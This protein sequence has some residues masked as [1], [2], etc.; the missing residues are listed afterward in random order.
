[1]RL[2]AMAAA[3]AALALAACGQPK[4]DKAAAPAE[5]AVTAPAPSTAALPAKVGE[6]VETALTDK[7]PRLEGMPE[8]GTSAT[9]ANGLA[10]VDY[11]V[12]PGIDHS[13][14]GD[15]VKLCLVSLPTDCPPGDD[16]GKIYKATNLRT[17]ESWTAPDSQH[18]CGGA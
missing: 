15:K 6:C 9:Y 3:T 10:Q 4:N 7:G 5:P 2:W 12:I 17:G 18:A 11:D 13:T 8:S 14:L 1:M 16:R